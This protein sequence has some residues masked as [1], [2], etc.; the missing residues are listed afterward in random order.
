MTAIQIILKGGQIMLVNIVF[1]ITLIPFLGV[2][3]KWLI[4]E[5]TMEFKGLED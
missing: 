5:M 3:M 4:K 2:S 1:F